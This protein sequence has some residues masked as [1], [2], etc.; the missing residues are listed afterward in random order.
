MAI[1]AELHQEHVN[2]KRLLDMLASGAA[3]I[4]RKQHVQDDYLVPRQM[5]RRC[6]PD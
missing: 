2:L 1:I 3:R 5:N 4:Q 6:N